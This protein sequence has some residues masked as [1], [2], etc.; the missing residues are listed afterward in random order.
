MSAL[1]VTTSRER[2]DTL[3]AMPVT[4]PWTRFE[5]SSLVLAGTSTALW[6]G[7]DGSTLWRTV[8]VAA[9]ALV[10]YGVV[11]LAGSSRRR[12]RG[13]NLLYLGVPATVMGAAIA[14]PHFAKEG[15]SLEATVAAVALVAGLALI[16]TGTMHLVGSAKRGRRILT[17]A[18]VVTV[19]LLAAYITIPSVAAVNVPS[20][21]HARTPLDVGL[22]A[23][24][25]SFAT[26]DGVTLHAWYVPSANGA[27]VIVRHGSGTTSSST[28]DHAAVLASHGFGVLLVDARGHGLS[29]GRAMDF[30]WYGDLDTRAA[31][32]FLVQRTDV[33][34]DA[35][36][37]LGL[38]MGGEEL[39][40]AAAADDRLRAVVAEGVTGRT[41]ADHR[42]FSEAYGVRGSVQEGIERIQSSF[43]D[44]LTEADKPVS[45]WTAAKAGPPTLLIAAGT[46]QDE[47]EVAA[48]LADVRP[49]TIATWTVP[50]ASHTDALDVDPA[51]WEARVVGFFEDHL[52][53]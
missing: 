43:T 32:D 38:S 40:G 45:L 25:V 26:A 49:S 30:G 50:G 13:L 15:A 12:V 44:L 2:S 1:D 48:R 7:L 6:T 33:Q 19:V 53:R 4:T 5:R 34:A 37:G 51:G 17:G 10:T 31:A 27:A 18:A 24:H 23:E 21:D 42:W 16:V 35:I 41:S 36:G 20:T 47:G 39:V 46:V 3:L 11:K 9:V 29:G 52:L 28:L 8:R 14:P 22:D